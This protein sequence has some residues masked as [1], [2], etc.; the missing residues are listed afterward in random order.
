MEVDL[1]FRYAGIRC[2]GNRF[3]L[4]GV[5]GSLCFYPFFLSGSR[6]G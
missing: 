3:F 5:M 2:D 1:S 6:G 4:V